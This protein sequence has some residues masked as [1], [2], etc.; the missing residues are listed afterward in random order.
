MDSRTQDGWSRG[1][2][3]GFWTSADR[4]GQ[5]QPEQR[6]SAGIGVIEAHRRRWRS[7]GLFLISRTDR[8]VPENRGVPGSIPGLAISTYRLLTR[9]ISARALPL[10]WG[11]ASGVSSPIHLSETSPS[12]VGA[13][14]PGGKTAAL[15]PVERPSEGSPT[16]RRLGRAFG[17][18]RGVR[19]RGWRRMDGLRAARRRCRLARRLVHLVFVRSSVTSRGVDARASCR[20]R[21]PSRPGCGAPTS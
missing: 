13:S 2:P 20:R 4:L 18:G 7:A 9:G 19:G 21:P 15:P 1:G 16:R 3:G 11:A 17:N 12:W 14:T 10:A 6:G 8:R 5:T